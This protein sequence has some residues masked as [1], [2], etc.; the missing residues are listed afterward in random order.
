[1]PV[2]SATTAAA[3]IL[4]STLA[5]LK[6]VR[7]RAKASKD[8]ELKGQISDLYDCVLSLKEA[9]MLVTDEN[10]ELLTRI[11]ALEHPAS[12]PEIKQVGFTNYY[13]VDEKGPFCQPCYDVNGKLIPLAPQVR[14]AGGL[15]RKCEV[16]NKV[17]FE[18]HETV[19]A[20]VE[21]YD[22]GVWS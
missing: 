21:P 8:S 18:N 4:S 11:A 10:R 12:K 9:V 5:V 20:H 1:M 17:F 14:Y 16:C 6:T 22:S 3:Q 2:T 15:G 19:Q 7:E 13:F